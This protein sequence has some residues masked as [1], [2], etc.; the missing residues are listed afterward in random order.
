MRHAPNVGLIE[1][2]LSG[3]LRMRDY[4]LDAGAGVY[5]RQRSSFRE[6]A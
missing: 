4:R 3:N 2:P 6:I 5:K 1:K